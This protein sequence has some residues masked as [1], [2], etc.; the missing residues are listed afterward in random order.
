MTRKIKKIAAIFYYA[1][2]NGYREVV[3]EV[4]IYERYDYI[5]I[6]THDF[7]GILYNTVLS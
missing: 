5:I 3:R 1:S 4:K 7:G 2:M 6:T